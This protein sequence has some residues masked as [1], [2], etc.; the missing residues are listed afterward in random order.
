[1]PV[2]RL[3]DISTFINVTQK[4]VIQQTCWFVLKTFYKCICDC[5]GIKNTDNQECVEYCFNA[6]KLLL[7]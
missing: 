4:I 5:A 7:W 2:L 1:M 3:M 6:A